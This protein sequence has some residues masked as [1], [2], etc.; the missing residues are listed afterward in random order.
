[1]LNCFNPEKGE[2]P[3]V[4]EQGETVV[5]EIQQKK[6]KYVTFLSNGIIFS[7]IIAS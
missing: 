1:M 2:Q 4:T 3:E 5:G 6:A 7:R